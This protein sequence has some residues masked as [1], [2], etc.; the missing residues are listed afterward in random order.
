MDNDSFVRD[1]LL[2]VLELDL[3]FDVSFF[4]W[5]IR[6]IWVLVFLCVIRV[7]IV[8]RVKLDLCDM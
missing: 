2:Y 5:V 6:D 3:G 4:G 7:I 1:F 8:V